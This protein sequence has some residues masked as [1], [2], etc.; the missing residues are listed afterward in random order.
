MRWKE[1]THGEPLNALER[2]EEKRRGRKKRECAGE[3]KVKEGGV[4]ERDG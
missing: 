1:R 2:K 3:R 4:G